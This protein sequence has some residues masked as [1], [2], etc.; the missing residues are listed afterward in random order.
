MAGFSIPLAKL[1]EKLKLDLETVARKATLDVFRAVA[2]RSPVRSGR[3]KANWN[4]TY[5]VPDYSTT[6]STDK[7]RADAEVAKVL[8]LAV[9]GVVWLANGL[10]YGPRLEHGYS[11]Q[12]PAGMVRLAATEFSDYVQKAIAK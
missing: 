1:A 9:G 10:P 2:I 7:G 5:G 12:A 3:F 4:V 11:Q 6:A 8:T